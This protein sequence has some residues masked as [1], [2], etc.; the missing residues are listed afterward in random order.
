MREEII[1]PEVKASKMLR[2][3]HEKFKEDKY[4]RE[5]AAIVHNYGIQ[6]VDLKR[7]VENIMSRSI[8]PGQNRW[9][10]GSALVFRHIRAA[11]VMAFLLL[12][13]QID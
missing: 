4:N 2:E 8:N 6:T 11:A 7:F 9:Y 1:S 12:S 5:I 3:G 13:S 10:H